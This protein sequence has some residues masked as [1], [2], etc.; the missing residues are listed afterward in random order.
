M[1]DL[2]RV[3]QVDPSADAEVVE[4][5][6]KRLARKFHPD[7]SPSPEA[8]SRI[9]ELNA[10]YEVLG[11][12]VRRAAYDGERARR[13]RTPLRVVEAVRRPAPR[14]AAASPRPHRPSR[15]RVALRRPVLAVVAAG[16]ALSVA[17]AAFSAQ[18][19]SGHPVAP[20]DAPAAAVVVVSSPREEPVALEPA[21]RRPTATPSGWPPPI[22]VLVDGETP[23]QP[24]VDLF[25]RFVG[26]A[27]R[28]TGQLQGPAPPERP[29]NPAPPSSSP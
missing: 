29:Y 6:Y 2:Y 17:A 26:A 28:V 1:A 9:R 15:D 4:V 19:F 21:T 20:H 22:Y 13:A 5:A 18:L 25:S 10:A 7:V 24:P 16:L 8:E 23:A 14:P 27:R 3:L 11:D 12:P